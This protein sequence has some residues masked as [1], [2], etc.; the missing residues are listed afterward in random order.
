[1]Y[2]FPVPWF[3]EIRPESE[4]ARVADQPLVNP[5]SNL[6]LPIG[7]LGTDGVL[8]SH[9]EVERATGKVGAVDCEPLPSRIRRLLAQPFLVFPWRERRQY[10]QVVSRRR[11]IA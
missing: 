11:E 1:A 6:D 7:V 3:V 9:V 5:G 8:A 2:V 10:L 4:F